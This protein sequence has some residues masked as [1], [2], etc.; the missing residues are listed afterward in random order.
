MQLVHPTPQAETDTRH[1]SS[2]TSPQPRGQSL[3]LCK[4]PSPKV[5]VLGLT[6]GSTTRMRPTLSTV[7]CLEGRAHCAAPPNQKR[8]RKSNPAETTPPAQLPLRTNP[9]KKNPF[10]FA[11]WKNSN[12]LEWPIRIPDAIQVGQYESE[13]AK[14]RWL[15]LGKVERLRNTK[16]PELLY[17]LLLKS[18]FDY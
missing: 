11:Y 3:N 8:P 13:K 17:D 12:D 7:W 1:S 14:S 4:C 15:F 9:E 5:S 6:Y 10:N 18:P 2:L 16:G